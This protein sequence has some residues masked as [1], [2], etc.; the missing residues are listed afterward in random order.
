[1]TNSGTDSS[2]RHGVT[3]EASMRLGDAY[4]DSPRR[5]RVVHEVKGSIKHVILDRN[6]NII[7]MHTPRVSGENITGGSGGGGSGGGTYL[8]QSSLLTAVT[9]TRSV[10]MKLDTIM[11]L[12]QLSTA[13][14]VRTLE[15]RTEQVAGL[16]IGGGSGTM[17]GAV[18]DDDFDDEQD[19][20]K[21]SHYHLLFFDHLENT[22]SIL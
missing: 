8:R 10:T 7:D 20:V 21:N 2:S 1:M 14:G 22:L 6:S 18:T 4:S 15:G 17:W 3:P 16:G 19:E 9:E 11:S 13:E 5:L 12:D